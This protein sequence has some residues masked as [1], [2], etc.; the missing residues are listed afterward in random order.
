MRRLLPLMLVILFLFSFSVASS[1][2]NLAVGIEL[3]FDKMSGLLSGDSYW[4]HNG[5]EWFATVVSFDIPITDKLRTSWEIKTFIFATNGFRFAP[6]S[7]KFTNSVSYQITDEEILKYRHYCHHYF[8]QFP[9]NNSSQ[10]D[11]I[12]VEDALQ[13][14][15]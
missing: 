4:L 8:K 11:K 1:P 6:S 10:G 2:E 14:E 5:K 3:Y 7:V 15:E 9:E 13:L 12:L